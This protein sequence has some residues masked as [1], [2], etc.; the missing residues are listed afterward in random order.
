MLFAEGRLRL[1]KGRR[2]HESRH[3]ARRLPAD[4]HRDLAAHGQ[5]CDD[6]SIDFQVIK[7]CDEIAGKGFQRHL[8]DAASPRSAVAAQIRSDHLP[9]Q[10]RDR[11]KLRP[12]HRVVERVAMNQ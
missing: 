11:L 12:P 3:S 2:Q 6:G 4:L 8:V 1:R 9:P 10:P 5:P 7:Q